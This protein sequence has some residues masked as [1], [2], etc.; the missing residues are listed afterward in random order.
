[1]YTLIRLHDGRVLEAVVLSNTRSRMRLA[2]AGLKDAVELR[3]CGSNWSDERN[4]P[5]EFGFLLAEAEERSEA[6]RLVRAAGR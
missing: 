3:L 6:P 4:E 1:M 2:A 5:V